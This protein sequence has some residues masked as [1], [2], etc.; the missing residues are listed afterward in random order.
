MAFDRLLA[1]RTGKM[2]VNII[3][4][5]LKVVSQ[6]GMVSLA[7]GIPAPESFPLEIIQNLTEMVVHKY[8]S[9]AFQYGP[10]EGFWPLREALAD[11]LKTR[12]INAGAGEI[13]IASGSQGVLDAI[14]DE[15]FCPSKPWRLT[16]LSISAPFQRFLHPV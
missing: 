1:D 13:L 7:G 14:G 5:I 15:M 6:P 9:E 10:T 12:D 4:E 8:G 3:R 11:Y 2:G 16:M